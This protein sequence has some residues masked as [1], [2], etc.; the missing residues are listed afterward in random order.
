M[1]KARRDEPNQAALKA[2]FEDRVT[3]LVWLSVSPK[4]SRKA[5]DKA[6]FLDPS[7]YMRVGVAGK[8]YMLHRIMWVLRNGE[9]P[10]GMNIDHIDGDV[11]NN[12]PENHRLATHFQ[13]M[14]NRAVL[15]NNT[16]GEPNV[17]WSKANQ[18]WEVR[19][20]AHGRLIARYRKS[21]EEAIAVAR[22]LRNAMHGEYSSLGRP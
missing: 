16:S 13:N 2:I 22:E 1:T 12:K 17:S 21:K 11:S 6:G 19:I 10:P 3:H 20:R 15:R 7:G 4:S 18:C 5:G 9:I 8:V 14:H